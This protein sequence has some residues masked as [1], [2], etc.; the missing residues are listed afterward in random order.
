LLSQTKY[1]SEFRTKEKGYKLDPKDA[2][3]QI[4]EQLMEIKFRGKNV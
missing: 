4:I 3:L 2:A 1:R